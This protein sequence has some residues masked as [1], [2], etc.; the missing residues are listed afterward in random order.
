MKKLLA[1]LCGFLIVFGIAGCSTRVEYN[2]YQGTHS[3]TQTVRLGTE[4]VIV[5][6]YSQIA[7]VTRAGLKSYSQDFFED[8]TLIVIIDYFP[9]ELIECNINRVTKKGHKITINL[10][11]DY[12]DSGLIPEHPYYENYVYVEVKAKNIEEVELLGIGVEAWA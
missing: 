12:A 4:Y 1:V 11:V 6:E 5:S 8:Y 3:S 2:F 10:Q 7:D 9:M